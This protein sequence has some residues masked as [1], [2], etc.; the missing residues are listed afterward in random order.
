MS[1]PTS[2]VPPVDGSASP[3]PPARDA[4][5]PGGTSP[6]VDPPAGGPPDGPDG[7]EGPDGADRRRVAVFVM[8]GLIVL[9]LLVLG[10]VILLGG[11]DDTEDT[12]A[13]GVTTTTTTGQTTSTTA[14]TSTSTTT[15]STS[16]TT[17]TTTTTTST[18]TTSSTTSTTAP[19]TTIDPE[20]C[21]GDAPADDPE[22]VA[23]VFYDAWTVEDVDCAE[24]VA[25]E[26][27]ID[28]LFA[29]DGSDADWTSQGC[30]TNEDADPPVVECAFAY[31]GGTAY[32][33]MRYSPLAGWSVDAVRFVVDE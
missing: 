25:S 4:P 24:E 33:E 21:D 2:P 31:D 22:P 29:I 11:D 13:G 6:P 14:A 10:L 15:T 32:F 18:T 26:D 5:P 27:A 9:A 20:R 23:Q 3:P 12:D 1:D 19:P 16:T 17:I 28:T 30:A 7:P 8:I